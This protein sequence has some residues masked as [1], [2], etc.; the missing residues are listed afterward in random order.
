MNSK[1][2]VMGLSNYHININPIIKKLYLNYFFII[3]KLLIKYNFQQ[4][5]WDLKIIGR[6]IKS[7]FKKDILYIKK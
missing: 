3:G 6:L 4:K 7:L 5:L 2:I 1:I